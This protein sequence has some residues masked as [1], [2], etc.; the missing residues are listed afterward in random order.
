MN[1]FKDILKE[2][3]DP[4]LPSKEVSS[5]D[6]DLL[7]KEQKQAIKRNG[8]AMASFSIAF[9]TDKA[10]QFNGRMGR[11]KSSFGCQRTNEAILFH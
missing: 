10:M 8:I 7:I 2:T 5:K 9:I 11:R 1:R 4:Y 3:Q 6:Y